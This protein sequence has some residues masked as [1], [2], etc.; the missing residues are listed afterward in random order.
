MLR[1]PFGILGDMTLLRRG[2]RHLVAAAVLLSGGAVAAQQP[3]TAGRTYTVKAGDSLWELSRTYLND[4]FL[5]PEIYRINA[6]GIEDPHWIYPGQVLQMPGE[7]PIAATERPLPQ[8]A[9]VVPNAVPVREPA[10]EPTFRATATPQ[11][12]AG[13]TSVDDQLPGTTVFARHLTRSTVST[14]VGSTIGVGPFHAVRQGEYYSSPW[15]DRPGVSTR[16]GRLS[17]VADIAGVG[18]SSGAYRLQPG[19][20]VYVTMPVGVTAK[21]DDRF[22]IV[23]IGPELEQGRQV[24]IPTGV[25]QVERSV[26]GEAI[27]ATIVLGYDDIKVGQRIIV[28]EPYNVPTDVRPAPVQSGSLT[29]ILYTPKGTVLPSIGHYVLLG[30]RRSDGVK[31]GDQYTLFRPRVR[32]GGMLPEERIAL[33]QIVRVTDQGATGIIVDQAQPSIRVGTAARLTARMP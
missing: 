9:A 23:A 28:I 12:V 8:P 22:L 2:A 13:A 10:H 31:I 27:T 17:G 14:E 30:A 32:A 1:T 20:R 18:A 33:V 4:P 19:A 6:S 15:L 3:L 7:M 16:M 21:H 11:R 29:S 5:W 26:P 25:I 24:V